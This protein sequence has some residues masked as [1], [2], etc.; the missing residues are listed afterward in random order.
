M[1]VGRHRTQKQ[2]H[3][4]IRI[5]AFL[6]SNAGCSFPAWGPVFDVA[7]H[8]MV[9]VTPQPPQRWPMG[10]LP[11]PNLPSIQRCGPLNERTHPKT[12]RVFRNILIESGRVTFITFPDSLQSP[13]AFCAIDRPWPEHLYDHY[14]SVWLWD[15][16]GRSGP[17]TI[18][19]RRRR[20]CSC[21]V[22]WERRLM[23]SSCPQM[24][25]HGPGSD[26][27]FLMSCCKS[28]KS[29]TALLSAL[30]V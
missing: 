4:F 6:I 17:G 23:L 10:W 24:V 19:K 29:H 16:A 7:I 27:F 8:I 11:H 25:S 20:W 5:K 12:F 14:A 18:W 28:G 13:S 1:N 9:V 3:S 30:R 26:C 21:Y 2:S 15:R 22:T